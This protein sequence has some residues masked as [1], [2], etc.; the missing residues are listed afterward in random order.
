MED[1]EWT[2]PDSAK[3][4]ESREKHQISDFREF[5]GKPDTAMHLLFLARRFYSQQIAT[6]AVQTEQQW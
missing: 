6:S 4:H 3:L 2:P 1:F 5:R